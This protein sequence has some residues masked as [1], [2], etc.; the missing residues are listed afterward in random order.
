MERIGLRAHICARLG[1]LERSLQ[2]QRIDAAIV[3]TSHRQAGWD[4]WEGLRWLRGQS[5]VAA[6][7][8]TDSRQDTKLALRM[9]ADDCLLQPFETEELAARVDALLRRSSE[10]GPLIEEPAALYVDQRF[11]INFNSRQVWVGNRGIQLT[12][13]EL[14]L[15]HSLIDNRDQPVSQHKLLD[16]VWGRQPH[17]LRSNEVLKQYVWRLRQKLESQPQHPRIIVTE[18]GSGYRFVSQD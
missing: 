14:A 17:D 13:R 12:P 5:D 10:A 8:I 3:D 9:G 2:E 11:W 16:I 6:L 18:P 1:E 7:V 4:G 15:L